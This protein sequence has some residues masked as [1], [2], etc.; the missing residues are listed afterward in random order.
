MFLMLSNNET[1]IVLGEVDDSHPSHRRRTSTEA[2]EKYSP[3]RC[4]RIRF[5]SFLLHTHQTQT[6]LNL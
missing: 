4:P 1:T 6:T 3:V 5:G 2:Y